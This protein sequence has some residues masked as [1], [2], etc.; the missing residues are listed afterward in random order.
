VRQRYASLTIGGKDTDDG[1]NL[2]MPMS[3]RRSGRIYLMLIPNHIN[4]MVAIDISP[5][6]TLSNSRPM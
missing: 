4:V 2:L 1:G 5:Q 3:T 6:R